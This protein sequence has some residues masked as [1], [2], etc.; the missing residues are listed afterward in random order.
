MDFRGASLEVGRPVG[1]DRHGRDF[2]DQGLNDN[3]DGEKWK[4]EGQA[5]GGI[6]RRPS[7]WPCLGTFSF[8]PMFSLFASHAR[9]VSLSPF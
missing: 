1:R 5:E 6:T 9:S 3:V 8:L 2:V 7:A 4:T